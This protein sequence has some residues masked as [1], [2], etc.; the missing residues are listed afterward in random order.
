MRIGGWIRM[1]ICGWIS[2]LWIRIFNC[3]AFFFFYCGRDVKAV[4]PRYILTSFAGHSSAYMASC[5]NT[6]GYQPVV[7]GGITNTF[8]QWATN[9]N[10]D[11]NNQTILII[12][13][14][15]LE[16]LCLLRYI[17]RKGLLNWL[18][19]SGWASIMSASAP[20]YYFAKTGW[21]IALLTRQLRP[22]VG[23]Q[24]PNGNW[25]NKELQFENERPGCLLY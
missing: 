22:W 9:L 15:N 21:T 6:R 25:L 10:A 7:V 23:D 12:T 2:R 3:L 19:K 14:A 16:A 17:S 11:Y 13:G 5:R 1:G 8:H 24:K 20:H 18:P 4:W